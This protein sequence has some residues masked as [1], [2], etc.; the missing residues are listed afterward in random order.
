MV[1]EVQV[2]VAQA[3]LGDEIKIPTLDGEEKIAILAGTQTGRVVS[4]KGKGIP[5]DPLSCRIHDGHHRKQA[6]RG[7]SG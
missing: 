1:L 4:I 6:S 5:H 3:A 7:E 2:N